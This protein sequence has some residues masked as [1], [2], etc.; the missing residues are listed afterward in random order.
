MTKVRQ[1]FSL[2]ASIL[3]G[4]G[5]ISVL[6]APAVHAQSPAS[7]SLSERILFADLAAEQAVGG[8]HPVAVIR[9]R[10][11]GISVWKVTIDSHGRYWQVF[12]NTNTYAVVKT[13]RL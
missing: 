1:S 12:V 5:L 7:I 4:M 13:V 8:G 11:N 2:A 9:S 6:P 10:L 3:L